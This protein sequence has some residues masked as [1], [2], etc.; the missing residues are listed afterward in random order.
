MNI[1]SQ[2]VNE[3]GGGNTGIIVGIIIIVVVSII[4]FFMYKSSKDEEDRVACETETWKKWNTETGVCDTNV[5]MQNCLKDEHPWKTWENDACVTDQDM[6]NEH[7]CGVRKD[8]VEPWMGWNSTTKECDV[9][10][11]EAKDQHDCENKTEAWYAWDDENKECTENTV[12]K[13]CLENGNTWDTE[14]EGCMLNTDTTTQL[15]RLVETYTED[16]EAQSESE[17]DWRNK[18]RT[19]N[20][21]EQEAQSESESDWRNKTRTSNTAEQE[22]QSESESDWRNKTRTS[23]TAEEAEAQALDL[24]SW[25]QYAEDAKTTLDGYLD[26]VNSIDPTKLNEFTDDGESPLDFYTTLKVDAEFIVDSTESHDTLKGLYDAL[27]ENMEKALE[28][29]KAISEDYT[30]TYDPDCKFVKYPGKRFG[31]WVPTDCNKLDEPLV[32]FS[33]P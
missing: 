29:H 3:G 27:K 11:E 24:D 22:A 26:Y 1:D 33:A 10:D 30:H 9:V 8:G 25:K 32:S 19:S 6:K 21:A 15:D 28:L 7:D 31:V 14:T 4:G 12:I 5:I 17:S 16:Q 23:N 20:T 13:E 2:Y 18:T